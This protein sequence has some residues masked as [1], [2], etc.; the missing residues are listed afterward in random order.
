MSRSLLLVLHFLSTSVRGGLPPAQD[1]EDFDVELPA[2]GLDNE[3]GSQSNNEDQCLVYFQ[4]LCRLVVI[5]SRVYHQLYSSQQSLGDLLG[6]IE[7]LDAELDEWRKSNPFSNESP[8]TIE[9]GDSLRRL[10]YIR[11]QLSYYHT[12]T[13]IHRMPPVLQHLVSFR[14]KNESGPAPDPNLLPPPSYKIDNKCLKVCRDSLKLLSLFPRG[15]IVW[16]W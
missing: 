5:K 8:Q 13:M 1:I 4:L 14:H 9:V 7:A 6:R 15:D 3:R 11:I 16:I 12:V 2:T 10:W